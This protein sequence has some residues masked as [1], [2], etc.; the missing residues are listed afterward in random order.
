[1]FQKLERLSGI[2]IAVFVYS[3]QYVFENVA[4]VHGFTD[5]LH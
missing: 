1:M 2:V 5:S 3:R 4:G